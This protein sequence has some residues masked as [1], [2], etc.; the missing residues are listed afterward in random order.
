VAALYRGTALES[1]ESHIQAATIECDLTQLG[2][3][4]P[5]IEVCL[6][7]SKLAEGFGSIPPRFPSRR[8]PCVGFSLGDGLGTANEP[9]EPASC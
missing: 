7:A 4:D 9:S 1:G 5:T 6:L 8:D 3:A 2:C